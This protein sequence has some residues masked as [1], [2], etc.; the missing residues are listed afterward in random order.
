MVPVVELRRRDQPAQRAEA[1]AH[2]GVDEDGLEGGQPHVSAEGLLAELHQVEGDERQRPGQ[3]LIERVDAGR[4]QPVHLRDAVVHGVEAPEE[5]H[6]MGEPVAEV[7]AEVGDQ[8]GLEQLQSARLCGDRRLEMGADHPMQEED[9]GGDEDEGAA[10]RER[11][12]EE[13]VQEI[14][15]PAFAENSLPFAQG[16][17][18]L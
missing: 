16:E 10:F 8:D 13:E 18:P 3:D 6:L 12:G 17:E 5:R 4:R 9:Q 15:S 2:V 1:Q 7:A 14:G 11:P